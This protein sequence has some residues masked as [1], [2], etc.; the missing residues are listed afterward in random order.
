MKN[1]VKM[2]CIL[3]AFSLVAVFAGCS[4]NKESSDINPT[5]EFIE[6]T[7]AEPASEPMPDPEEVVAEFDLTALH[8]VDYDGNEFA[9]AWKITDGEGSQFESFVYMFDGSTS[10]YLMTGTMGYCGKYEL[11][12]AKKQFTSQLMFGIDGCYNYEFSDDKSTVV[13]TNTDGGK[14]TTLEKIVS[15]SYIP[16][17]DSEPVIDKELLGAWSDENGEYL[18]FEKNGIMYE[19]QLGVSFTFYS[20]SAQDGTIDAVYYMKDKETETMTYSV[21]GDTLTLNDYEYTRVSVDELA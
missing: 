14:T 9:G 18:Y 7:T 11:D 5:D 20:Y 3:L 19:T 17:P 13:L 10:A 8:A 1:S 12:T 2:I 6:V 21:D 15:F 16:I 4:D